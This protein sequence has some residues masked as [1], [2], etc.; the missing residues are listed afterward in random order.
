MF[1]FASHQR[2][3]LLLV[4]I[5]G[6]VLVCCRDHQPQLFSRQAFTYLAKISIADS[7]LV[8]NVEFS[9]SKETLSWK[10]SVSIHSMKSAHLIFPSSLPSPL[11]NLERTALPSYYL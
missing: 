9:T 8:L 11:S 1:P 2:Q 10:V 4:E 6:L 5:A 3:E 7:R